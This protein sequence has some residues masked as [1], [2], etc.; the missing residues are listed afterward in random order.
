[1]DGD[2]EQVSTPVKDGGKDSFD[3]NNL[4]IEQIDQMSYEDII[5]SSDTKPE[6]GKKEDDVS[7][8]K[9]DA[10][11]KNPDTYGDGEKADGQI[12][13]KDTD[14]S[15]KKD[16]DLS[17]L[18]EKS[19]ERI[20]NAQRELTKKSMEAAEL[21]KENEAIRKQNE[22]LQKKLDE[23]YQEPTAEELE[24]LK[25]TDVDMYIKVINDMERRKA[26]REE[27]EAKSLEAKQLEAF[28]KSQL[29]LKNVFEKKI[30]VKVDNLTPEQFQQI[31]ESDNWKNWLSKLEG[32][33]PDEDGSFSQQSIE[34]AFNLAN[35]DN[36]MSKAIVNATQKTI[37]S[38]DKADRKPSIDKI[39]SGKQNSDTKKSVDDY[40]E[41]EIDEMPYE[42]VVELTE[43]K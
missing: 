25:E 15:G 1:M 10:S 39:P 38:I 37:D 27:R 22:E 35:W 32:M 4:T 30:G 16:D 20:K 18:D 31:K 13:D 21:R 12:K 7:D 5:G 40:T 3:D 26:E 41:A 2:V 8:N 14:E 23:S 6:P 11:G 33:R 29:N 19:Q 28:K 42:Q 43:R 9:K 36:E 24:E 34:D 17:G